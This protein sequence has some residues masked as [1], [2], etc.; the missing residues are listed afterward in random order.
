MKHI[1]FF[2]LFTVIFALAACGSPATPAPE[3]TSPP[4]PTNTSIPEPTSTSL[5]PTAT[6]EPSPTPD[7]LLFRD[8][9][10]GSLGEGWTWTQ[11]NK[12]SWS[13][14]NNPG[15]L[16]IIARP[17]YV[18]GGNLDNILLRP[19]PDGNFEIEI[20]LNFKPVGDYQIAGLLIYESAANYLQFGRA[21]CDAPGVCAKDGF[22]VDLSTNGNLD[23]QN[24]ATPA[25]N[26][27]I[28]FLR[29]RREGNKYTA[30]ASHDGQEWR[31]IGEKISDMNPMFIGLLAGQAWS[32]PQPAQF[33]YFIVN[34]VP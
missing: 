26:T 24:L 28:A 22:Y 3:P 20:K 11:E 12:K 16:E 25:E 31:L 17:G 6:L 2:V 8:D 30:Y 19:I 15:W 34:Q 14:T 4:L 27:E 23:G 18:G 33:D 1:K 7:P 5:P 21:F 10:E 9:F 13:L 32:A 29:L